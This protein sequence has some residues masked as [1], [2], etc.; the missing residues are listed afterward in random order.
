VAKGRIAHQQLDSRGFE[1]MSFHLKNQVRESAEYDSSDGTPSVTQDPAWH[2]MRR[3]APQPRHLL[4]ECK[5][6]QIVHTAPVNYLGRD[7]VESKSPEVTATLAQGIA[8]RVGASR[9]RLHVASP[10]RDESAIFTPRLFVSVSPWELLAHDRTD[11]ER[12]SDAHP[13]LVNPAHDSDGMLK[14]Q[15]PSEVLEQRHGTSTRTLFDNARQHEPFRTAARMCTRSATSQ[16][17]G[18][19]E[20]R[21][22]RHICS[23]ANH[24]GH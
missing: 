20:G 5:D 23:D 1:N 6:H 17:W 4:R 7:G 24:S 19:A 8:P 13:T 11:E 9:I 21:D 16:S 2:G 18:S 15:Y 3:E 10:K 22:A 14:G 12:G